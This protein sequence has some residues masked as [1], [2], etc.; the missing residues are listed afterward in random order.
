MQA[1]RVR[2]Q[3][4]LHEK[5]TIRTL[6]AATLL[7]CASAAHAIP[8]QWTDGTGANGH[9][10]QF[11]AAPVTWT[12]AQNA[13]LAST[14]LGESGHLAT[15]TSA[16]ENQF[17]AVVVAQGM[18]AW[19]G[20][21]DE[22]NPNNDQADEGKWKW[23][24]GPEAGQMFWNKGAKE[25]YSNWNPGEPNNCCGGEDYLQI[26]WGT[27]GGWNDHTGS[28]LN[29]YVIEYNGALPPAAAVPE[30]GTLALA[31]TALLG[32]GLMRRRKR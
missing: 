29:G 16:E 31:A 17:V 24:G 23:M 5:M 11:V 15:I 26:N 18:V 6:T 7:V 10:Y 30:P 14:W 3:Q 9:W 32:L 8:I 19:L 1:T 2:A 28:Q 27:P 13:A 4:S 12:A 22:W 25:L 20:G 21:S